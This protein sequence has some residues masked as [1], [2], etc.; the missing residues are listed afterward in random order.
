VSSEA[1]DP[2][3]YDRCLGQAVFRPHAADLAE[4]AGALGVQRVLELAA[5]TGILTAHLVHAL[6]HA[7]VTATDLN[8]AMVEFGSGPGS[9]PGTSS[10]ATSSPSLWAR[11]WP[12]LF[13]TIHPPS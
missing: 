3:I 12:G 5:G 2:E 6:P 13:R 4:R 9:I 8:P 1:P 10:N 7:S 11:A